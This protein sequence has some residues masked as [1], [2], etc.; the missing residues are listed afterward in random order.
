MRR[1]Y[2]TLAAALSMA[3]AACSTIASIPPSP[4]AVADSVKLDEQIGLSLTLAYTAS[5]KAAGLAITTAAALGKPFAPATVKRIGELDTIAFAAVTAVR[6]AY[7]AGNATS[8][9]A[10]ISKARSAIADFLSAVRGPGASMEQP[11]AV[12]RALATADQRFAE[13]GGAR[14]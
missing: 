11:A 10:A 1:L 12:E 9:L 14:G 7:K 8:Y 6:A 5:A 3:V 13:A 4:A 2:L